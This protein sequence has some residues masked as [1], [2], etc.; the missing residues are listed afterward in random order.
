VEDAIARA[1]RVWSDV[2]PLTFQRVFEEEGD[3]VLSF[4]RG[5]KLFTL[6]LPFNLFCFVGRVPC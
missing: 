3:I 6:T 4:H 2:T 1:F 5:G